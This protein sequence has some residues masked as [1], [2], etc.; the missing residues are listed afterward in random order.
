M[1]EQYRESIPLAAETGKESTRTFISRAIVSTLLS[2]FL[3]LVWSLTGGGFFWPVLPMVGLGIAMVARAVSL[4]GDYSE[5]G[6]RR[7]M[8]DIGQSV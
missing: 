8:E 7:A 5:V 3:V 4:F 2:A 1:Q 6:I